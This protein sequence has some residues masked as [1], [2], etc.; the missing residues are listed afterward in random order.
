MIIKLKYMG[1]WCL[2]LALIAS[3]KP[4]ATESTAITPAHSYYT[5][6]MH[7]QVHE[8]H[9]GNC[10]ICG[11]KLINVEMT[12]TDGN[13]LNR[14]VLTATQIQLAGIT[15]DTVKQQSVGGGTTLTGTVT[16]DQT[17]AEQLSARVAGRVQQ[18]FVRA[19]GCL[20][21]L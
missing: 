18:L 2:L 3:C 8:D 19:T 9:P 10:P 14:I 13:I 17:R 15:T 5:C 4:K 11:M 1:F 12:Y 21:H 16:T 6:S 7:P 20:Q